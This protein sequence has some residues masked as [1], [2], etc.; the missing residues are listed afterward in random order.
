VATPPPEGS[1]R[2]A[3]STPEP[4]FLRGG[5]ELG[6]LIRAR[7]WCS[8]PLGAPETWPESLKLAIALLLNSDQPMY[9]WWGPELLC[10]YND[11]YRRSIGSERHPASLGRPGRAVWGEI[12]DIIGPQIERVMSG[13]GSVSFENALVPITRDGRLERVYWTYTYNPILV[14]SAGPEVGGVLVICSE[15]TRAVLS[16]ERT[17][18]EHRQLAELFEQAPIFMAITRGP[19]HRFELANPNYNRLV[20]HRPV[21]G[22]T[23][24]EALPEAAEQGY[25]ALLDRVYRTGEPYR[26]TASRIKLQATATGPPEDRCLDFVYQPMRDG[27][28]NVTGIFIAGV[29]TT[30]RTQAEAAL[31]ESEARF[32]DIAD[33]TPVLSWISDVHKT[34]IWFNN[35]WLAFTGRSME[36]ESGYGWVQG[37]HPD[38]AERCMAAYSTAFDRRESYRIEYRRRRADGEWR[39]LDASGVPRYVDDEFVGYIGTCI[40]IT[41]QRAAARALSDSEEQLRLATEAAEVGLWDLDLT[42]DTLYWPPRVKAMFGIAAEQLVSMADFYQG[43]HPEDRERTTVAFSAAIDPLRRALYD[44]EYRTVGKADGLVRWV[45]AKGR[46]VFRADRCVRVIG[47]AIDITTRKAAEAQL[48]ELNERLEQRVAR[49]LAERKVFVDIIESTDARVLVLDLGFRIMAINRVCAQDLER[50]YGIRARVGDDLLAALDGHPRERARVHAFWSRALDGEEFTAADEFGDP[51]LERRYYEMKF[52]ALRDRDGK[53]L[54]AFQFVYDITDRLKDQARLAEAERN[55]RQAQKIDAIGQLTGGVA[56]DFNNLLMVI[57]GGLSLLQ[58]QLDGERRDRIVE[59][60]RQAADRGA[61]LV[62]QLLTFARTQPLNATPLDLRRQIDGMRELLDRTLRGDV[63]VKTDLAADLWPIKVDAAE[64][65]LVVLNLCVNA[66]DAMPRGGVIT[67]GARN[68]PQL[69]EGGSPDDRVVLSVT[70]TGTGMAADVLA[71]VF[72]PFFTTKEIGKGTGLGLPQVYGFVQRSGGRVQV[73]SAVGRGT[74]VTLSLPRTRECPAPPLGVRAEA[75][76]P[77][78]PGAALESILIVEDDD[79]VAAL[80]AEMVRGL[81]YRATRVSS[82]PAALGAL[83]DDR[84][85]DL[86]F[87]DIMMPGPMNGIDLAREVRRRRSS[88]PVLL[89]SGFAERA[90]QGATGENFR[91]LAKPYALAELEQALR[92]ALEDRSLHSRLGGR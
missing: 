35:R 46:G 65:E 20:G 53:L 66:R 6:A 59:Q 73:D 18:S 67:I 49:A 1:L 27:D 92:A 5:G 2:A 50:L 88:L 22:R 10:F 14:S 40:D 12:W 87:S 90:L 63:Q 31:R 30:D 85:I 15:T 36:Q 78:R 72:E 69:A 34:C 57:S 23:V 39:L 54:G 4:S 41:D 26:A 28:Q 9:I 71:H 29:D 89:T 3:D 52:N 79:E 8:S 58:R 45:A 64:L 83:A 75:A 7:D 47:T 80:V 61:S 56:H 55:L 19:E 48:H 81:G 51:G 13:A 42:T 70:D 60:M 38:D 91:V 17:A 68:A 43:L 37:V 82:A 44:V 21:I 86:V 11:A 33:A 62:R 24:A 84:E 76:I 32:R 16:A 74:T 25:T 77:A